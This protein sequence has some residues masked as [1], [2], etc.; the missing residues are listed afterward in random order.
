MDGAS[1]VPGRFGETLGSSSGGGRQGKAFSLSVKGSNQDS[2]TGC[3]TGTRSTGQ[4]RNGLS[5]RH[6]HRVLLFVR[7][8][9][10]RKDKLVS[11]QIRHWQLCKHLDPLSH[12]FF[13]EVQ[14][15]KIDNW[16]SI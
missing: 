10:I 9:P 1:R 16:S 8:I 14:R 3:F 13:S 5:Q 4:D 12:A 2:E 15:S 7:Q 11:R 6:S